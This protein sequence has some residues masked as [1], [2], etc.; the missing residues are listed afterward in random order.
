MFV[1]FN[2]GIQVDFVEQRPECR[3]TNSQSRA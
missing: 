3:A 1:L 2:P